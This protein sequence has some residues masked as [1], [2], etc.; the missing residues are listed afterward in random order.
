MARRDYRSAEA[1]A[2][3]PLYKTAQWLRIRDAQLSVHPL[4]VMCEEEGRVTAATV[5]DHIAPHK[6][7]FARFYAGPFQSLCAS[8]HSRHKQSEER[9]GRARPVTGVDGWPLGQ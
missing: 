8:H 5:C 6:G 4:C 3:R 7:D 1:R 9:T 2:Y